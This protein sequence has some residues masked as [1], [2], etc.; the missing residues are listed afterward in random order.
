MWADGVGVV[1]PGIGMATSAPYIG[2]GNIGMRNIAARDI[3][4]G[5]IAVGDNS[6]R[7][8][9]VGDISPHYIAVPVTR[10]IGVGSIVV[11]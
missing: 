10:G 8:I 2:M 1:A 4:M 5:N 7:H 11:G 9:A 3:A 6:A